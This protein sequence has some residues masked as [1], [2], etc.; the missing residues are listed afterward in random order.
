MPSSERPP[1]IT[2]LELDPPVELELEQV[3]RDA[4]GL[5]PDNA[6][7]RALLETIDFTIERAY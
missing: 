4:L 1:R 6:A 2:E 5:F 3:S 7:K